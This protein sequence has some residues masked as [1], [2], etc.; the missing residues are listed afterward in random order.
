MTDTVTAEFRS[1]GD[2]G[3]QV[4]PVDL[5]RDASLFLDFDGTLV[6][7]AHRP[8]GVLVDARLRALVSRLVQDMN[9]RVAIVSGRPIAAIAGY[10]GEGVAI[11]GSHGLEMR[12]PDGRERAPER[13]ATLDMVL[14]RLREF[15][16]DREGL[17]V[18]EK[19]LG[20][21]LHYRGAESLEA[22]AR[23]LVGRLAD[24][25]GLTV[26]SGKKVLE[27]RLAGAHKGEAIRHFLEG[28]PFA[29]FRPVFIGDDVTDEDGFAAVAHI[30]GAGILV[31]DA[32]PTDAR[33]RL[34]GVG[35]TLDWLE[36]ACAAL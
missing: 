7:I 6:E 21:G 12:W 26:Q 13:P 4:P 34:A 1:A 31:G 22:E 5:L 14:A 29:G 27:L 10:L 16:D 3:L 30:G 8:D 11:S 15:A 24:E 25:T 33:Y 32:R 20:V 9:G 19:P 2:G 36:A 28:P 35:S 18:E 23:E 17:L